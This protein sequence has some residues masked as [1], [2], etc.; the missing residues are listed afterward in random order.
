MIPAPSTLPPPAL[1][2]RTAL[3]F[4]PALVLLCY[5]TSYSE[6]VVS[7][8]SPHSLSPPMNIL[9]ALALL[10]AVA[11]P[12]HRG[13][14]ASRGW[15][16]GSLFAALA[17]ALWLAATWMVGLRAML[18]G[19]RDFPPVPP[20]CALIAAALLYLP[21][22]RRLER[23][24]PLA[25]H[26]TIAVYLMLMVGTLV[27]SYA[28]AHFLLPTMVAARYYSDLE[29]KWRK[30]LPLLPD[31]FGP[32]NA[33]AIAGFWKGDVWQ[34]P[35][36]DWLGPLA[37]WTLL[38]VA[39]V[40]VMFC[41]NVLVRRQWIE[42]E[43]LAFPL[44]Q[45]PLELAR[46]EPGHVLNR[47][48]RNG[49][50]W[51]GFAVPAVL[52]TINGLHQYFPSFP[53]L[54]FRHVNVAE[55][56]GEPPWNAVKSLDVTFY[57]CVVG[58]SYLLT[59]E[60][61]LSCWL[62]YLVRKLLPALGTAT[63]WSEFT[64]PN[65]QIFPFADQQA[66]GA[67]V[68]IVLAALWTGRRE[69]RRILD[70]AIRGERH[71]EV[72]GSPL[73]YRAALLGAVGGIAFLVGW[74]WLARMTPWVALVFIGLFFVSCV[75][76]TRIRA[77]A[78]MGGLT[79]PMTP[80]ET[81]F[82]LEGTSAFGPQNL[83]V[84]QFCRW[85]T[86]DLRGL[87]CIMSSQ[88]EDFKMADSIRLNPRSLPAALMFA[89][90]FSL[91]AAYVIL[92]PVVYQYGGVTMN[93]MRFYE[94]P[95]TPF[96]ELT[97]MLQTPRRPHPLEVGAAGFGLVFTLLLS[98]LR[99]NLSWWPLHP[100]G[101]AVGFS[102]RTVDWM[103]FSIFLGWAAK[104]AVLRLG[105]MRLYRHLL[106]IFLGFILGEFFMGGVFGLIGCLFPETTGYQLYP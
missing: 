27:T 73:S 5:W 7:A 8:T 77:E 14:V 35:W 101:Y 105:G 95:T 38:V 85:M 90:L 41:L 25:P 75:A 9:T 51:A 104:A 68:A 88:L 71:D 31:W 2:W 67:W 78:G 49:F 106:P 17:L 66:T 47:Y 45:L 43:R 24:A 93:R 92:L 63:G 97:T 4:C 57:P 103:W 98:A 54:Q 18:L 69:M 70:R 15:A 6:G 48:Y 100:I 3:V 16:R 87:A 50:T 11:V 64:T 83:V 74:L 37:A 22:R 55:S 30:W 20:W 33:R 26:E 13:I 59:L 89:L 65:G 42:N 84:L 82:M 23:S 58:I 44:V 72:A 12:V 21:A 29:T 62:F 61:S 19:L 34:V 79:G 94:V 86:V 32:K 76:L 52:H 10:T 56:W 81:M 1:T 60:V 39:V 36:G 28:T 96:R 99:L 40:W 46:Q 102:R 91:L 80:Q 53:A